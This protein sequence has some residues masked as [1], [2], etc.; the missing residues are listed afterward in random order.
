M[1]TKAAVAQGFPLADLAHLRYY[2]EELRRGA[3]AIGGAT[4]HVLAVTGEAPEDVDSTVRRY[5]Q[6]PALVHPNLE[7]GSKLSAIAFLMKM[8]ATPVAK[9]DEWERDR[10]YPLLSKSEL[11]HDSQ[12]WLA[13]AEHQA[14]NLL[15]DPAPN[16][17]S[18]AAQKIG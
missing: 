17:R 14:L 2:T 13:T 8:M 18:V 11:A 16:I 5:V 4:D 7:F 6:N 10:G 3:F 9:L 15:P 1:F 12:A